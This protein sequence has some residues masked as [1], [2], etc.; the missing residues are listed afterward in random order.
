[1]ADSLKKKLDDFGKKK[2]TK[3]ENEIMVLKGKIEK[4]LVDIEKH[5]REIEKYKDLENVLSST[6]SN[7]KKII[8]EL[9][10]IIQMNENDKKLF[11]EEKNKLENDFKNLNAKH[12]FQINK[13]KQFEKE[14]LEKEALSKEI[15]C[16]LAKIDC[17]TEE[18]KKLGEQENKLKK[19]L[20]EKHAHYQKNLSELRDENQG[21][22]AKNV[23]LNDEINTNK[24]KIKSLEEDLTKKEAN[25]NM[26]LEKNEH[27]FS[28]LKKRSKQENDYL[29]KQ[30]DL[31]TQKVEVLRKENETLLKETNS[32]RTTIEELKTGL[33]KLDDNYNFLIEKSQLENK[34]L[35]KKIDELNFGLSQCRNEI[36]RLK[37]EKENFLNKQSQFA[38]YMMNGLNHYFPQ[39]P[40]Q[41]NVVNNTSNLLFQT[42]SNQVDNVE[43]KTNK[44]PR[45]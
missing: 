5:K 28:I 35:V 38:S 29:T 42:N 11:Q 21:L 27:E 15:K 2:I 20:H 40:I 45:I 33:N 9:K 4:Q 34:Q 39:N 22:K 13:F 12:S 19:E 41:N 23:L 3:Y 8:D 43:N 6:I 7:D 18:K 32:S 17:L 10:L 16:L 36:S 25:F 31:F 37:T 14:I 44:R 30:N 26:L 1:M 24:I